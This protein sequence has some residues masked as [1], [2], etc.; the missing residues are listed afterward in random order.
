ME[1]KAKIIATLGPAIY[2]STKLKQLVNLGVDAF[3]INFSHNTH[4]VKKI[5]S[6][7]RKIER[8]A[9]KKLALIA[10]LQGVKLRVGNIKGDSQKIKYNQK[11]TFDTKRNIGDH[12]RINFPYPKILKKLKKGNKILIDDG[13]FTFVVTKKKGTIVTTICKSQN[14]FMKSNKSV[15]IPNFDI[16]FNKLTSKDKKDIKTA[17]KLGCNWI[18]LSYLQSEKLIIEARKLIKKDMGIISKIE[19]KHALK[20]I[21]KIIKATDSV[22]IARGD[23]AI[24]IGHSEVPKVQLSLIKKCSQFSKSVI[25]AT[26]MLESMIENNTA[27]RAEINDIATAIFQGA[28]TV[29]LSA[30]AAIGKFPTQAVS[31]MT[32]TILSTEKYKR[33]HIEDFKNSIIANKDPV[34]SILLSVKDMAY[35][36]NVK[37]IIVFSNSGKSAKLVSAMRPAAKIVTISPNINVSRQVSLLWGV[38]SINSRDAN[39]WK[40]MMSISKEIIKKLKFIKKN[41]FVVITAGLPFGKA[42]MTN[43]IRLYKVGS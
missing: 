32:E 30:E 20:N 1:K 19:N 16:S 27:T 8:S 36:S 2:S 40:D 4:G 6:K 5:V 15:H 26:Q 22:M 25:V 9:N 38:Q 3:R 24:D 21:I 39:G 11:Y 31:T 17:I 37:A 34:K 33:E 23:L 18:A 7:I 12:S 29:M 43:M 42:G 13:K 14:C 41:D 35:N 28:D 10:D